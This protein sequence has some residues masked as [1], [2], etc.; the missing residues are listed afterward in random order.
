MMLIATVAWVKL[1]VLLLAG[2]LIFKLAGRACCSAPGLLVKMLAVAAVVTGI[3]L[4]VARESDQEVVIEPPVKFSEVFH[5]VHF[6]EDFIRGEF[7]DPH[8]E[9]HV[10]VEDSVRLAPEA[11]I[12]VLGSGL[13]I[14]GAMLFGRE[15]TR[16]FALKALTFLGVGA[17]IFAVVSFFGDAPRSPRL[18]QRAVRHEVRS[19]EDGP[20]RRP[21]IVSRNSRARR[22]SIRP[23]RPA[24]GEEP[25]EIRL[26]ERAGEIPVS[27]E[28]EEPKAPEPPVVEVAAVSEVQEESEKAAPVAPANTVAAADPAPAEEKPAEDQPAESKPAAEAAK[29][30][31]PAPAAAPE[32]EPVP[33]VAARRTEER[34]PWVD[35]KSGLT[36]SVYSLTVNTGPYVTVPE[37][38]RVL[39]EEIQEK[40][41]Q[42]INDYLGDEHAAELVSIP[43]EYLKRNV[44]KSEY[45]EIIDSK[46]VGSMY[47]LHALLEFDDKARSDFQRLWRN[48]V[49]RD[50]LWY[51]GGGAALVLALLATFYGYLRLDLKTDSSHKGRLQLAATLVALI[52]AAGALIARWAVAF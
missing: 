14:L 37:C 48:A 4:L 31:Q 41:N 8:L 45:V 21:S 50:R 22:P 42:Y 43:L 15:R 27:V 28:V 44:K 17:I 2:L 19:H 26:P 51:T 12:I 7:V 16:P 29:A 1:L 40:A 39:D 5:D 13:I 47:Q 6:D 52:V 23:E 25:E 11:W 24:P 38:Q 46:S 9:G 10:I 36:G 18:A 20:A 34:P 49:V 32:A 30:E 33:L 3:W 35:S